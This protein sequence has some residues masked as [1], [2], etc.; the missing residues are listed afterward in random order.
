M[1]VSFGFSVG[2]FIAVAGLVHNIIRAISEHNGAVAEYQSCVST[3]KSLHSCICAIKEGLRFAQDV[4]SLD[5]HEVALLNGLTYELNICRDLLNAFLDSTYKYTASL[6]P[7]GEARKF[8]EAQA[9][10]SLFRRGKASM[11]RLE[12]AWKKVSWA[13]FRKEDVR[14]LEKDL[15]GHLKALQLYLSS[16]E[17]LTLFRLGNHAA[18]TELAIRNTEATAMDILN[19]LKPLIDVLNALPPQIG[20]KPNHCQPIFFEDA[21]G[22]TIEIPREFCVSKERFER[23]LEILFQD[24][25]GHDKVI[26]KQYQL[27]D[28]KGTTVISADAWHLKVTAG[29]KIAMTFLFQLAAKAQRSTTEVCPKCSTVNHK[30]GLQ[31]GMTECFNCKLTFEIIDTKF[32]DRVTDEAMHAAFRRIRYLRKTQNTTLKVT[33]QGQR[34]PGYG[35]FYKYRC[36]YFYTHECPNWVYVNN[37]GCGECSAEG[38]D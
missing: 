29:V 10:I 15:Q 12:T 16:L 31:G 3:L 23:H 2:D 20:D 24:L 14:K 19:S 25:P 27:E 11:K 32:V 8:N 37:T 30:S 18:T 7:S 13:I 4:S 38:R 22:R 6:L 17:L 5:L 33:P 36:K 26:N 35:G 28:P 1:P 9:V 21:L 34:I